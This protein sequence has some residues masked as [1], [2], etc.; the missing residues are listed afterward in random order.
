[1][2]R[3]SVFAFYDENGIV[4]EYITY[5]LSEM[6][7]TV[8]YQIVVV[9]GNLNDQGKALIAPFTDQIIMREN[10]GYDIA[11]YRQAFLDNYDL[12]LQYDQLVFYNQSVFGPFYPFDEMFSK[13]AHR[14]CDFWGITMYPRTDILPD[15]AAHIGYI[16]QHIQSY[17]LVINKQMLASA[18][19]KEYFENLCEINTYFD[20]VGKFE[21]LF[22]K[23][24]NDIGY[25]SKAYI[26]TTDYHKLADYP[27]FICPVDLIKNKRCPIAKRKSFA[28]DRNIC[29]TV[30][31]G[32]ASQALYEYIHAN[33]DYDFNMIFKNLIRT[34][35]LYTLSHSFTPCYLTRE[36][37]IFNEKVL[38]VVYL[39]SDT[40]LDYIK[41]K[42]DEI[43]N[44][45]HIVVTATD[46]SLLRIFA[47][48]DTRTVADG[49]ASLLTLLQDEYAY[50]YV[51]YLT[52]HIDKLPDDIYD[53][54]VL[55]NS[56]N[57]LTNIHNNINI[58]RQNPILGVLISLPSYVGK[59][60]YK[61]YEWKNCLASLSNNLSAYKS[62][63]PL[64]KQLPPVCNSGMFFAKSS[65]LFNA[66]KLYEQLEKAFSSNTILHAKDV[67][68]PLAAQANSAMTGFIFAEKNLYSDVLNLD[69]KCRQIKNIAQT[70]E[71]IRNDIF[72]HNLAGKIE[73][74]E[75]HHN[76]MTLKQAFNANLGFKQ[77]L[78]IIYHLFFAKE[79]G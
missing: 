20:A 5:L 53:L 74:F 72:C 19:L 36:A 64:G 45:A 48:Y 30:Y 38:I 60:F 66:D 77:K 2:K 79:K 40:R 22:T 65:V 69:S 16:P 34:V 47:S 13:M 14:E 56:F 78:Y 8:D 21:I 59:S 44:L 31:Y 62:T 25:T 11:G 3:I 35:D 15:W 42:L 68:I 37:T 49:Y 61:D 26:D 75:E 4:D 67:A 33:T 73:Y 1:M 24:F 51:A 41:E 54:S 29:D 32:N 7:K 27:L 10:K 39:S 18:A 43:A 71:D 12:I 57:T 58:L 52:N 23:H 76:D 17:F 28:F 9:N 63:I 55:E 70:S 50:N 6:K 46:S